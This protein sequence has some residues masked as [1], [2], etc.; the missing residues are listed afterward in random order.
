MTKCLLLVLARHK[1]GFFFR[2]LL[3]IPNGICS[4]EAHTREKAFFAGVVSTILRS[5]LAGQCPRILTK[6][7]S[8][9]YITGLEEISLLGTCQKTFSENC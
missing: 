1:V 7:I 8:N 2:I 5:G 3:F 4:N 6:L 9:T